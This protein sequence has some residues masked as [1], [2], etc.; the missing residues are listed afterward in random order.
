MRSKEWVEEDA[1]PIPT[2]GVAATAIVWGKGKASHHSW[3]VYYAQLC[4]RY[5]QN[6]SGSESVLYPK[7]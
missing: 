4:A 5:L 6:E 1:V 3:G 2:E 7:P